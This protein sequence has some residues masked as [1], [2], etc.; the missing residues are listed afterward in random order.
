MSI[1]VLQKTKCYPKHL[2]NSIGSI[3]VRCQFETAKNI[4]NVLK[5]PL[6]TFLLRDNDVGLYIV[7]Y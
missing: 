4:L 7:I 3:L 6:T 1:F 2:P 5:L